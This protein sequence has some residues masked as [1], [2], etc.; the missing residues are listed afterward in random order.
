MKAVR[1]ARS[2]AGFYSVHEY[3]GAEMQLGL[4]IF[5]LKQALM[6]REA[7]NAARVDKERKRDTRTR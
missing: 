2:K 4:P 3:D 5:S 6:I 1:V 7:E